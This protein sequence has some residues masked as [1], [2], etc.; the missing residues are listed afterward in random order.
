MSVVQTRDGSMILVGE[1]HQ[2]ARAVASIRFCQKM[3]EIE[4]CLVCKGKDLG[5][6]QTVLV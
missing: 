6:S 1:G 2:P 3:H 5:R 4:K